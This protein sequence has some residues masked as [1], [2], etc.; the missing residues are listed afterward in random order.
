MSNTMPANQP[1]ANRPTAEKSQIRLP[2]WRFWAAIALQSALIVAVPFKSALTYTT[3]KTVT[4]QTAPVDPYDIFRGYSQTLSYEI[5]DISLLRELPGGDSV[6]SEIGDGRPRPFYVTL[7]ETSATAADIT[8]SDN[9]A[10]PPWQ[11]VAVSL[12]Q[13]K[14]LKENQ[15][16]LQ[17]HSRY[18]SV[19]YGLETY[20]MPE[21]QRNDI[22]RNIA[23][24]RG[25]NEAFVV[26]V[27]VDGQGTSVLRSL[28]IEGEEYRF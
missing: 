8:A 23:N 16:A 5:S 15:V 27:K 4:I 21:A 1:V 7:E 14:L 6:F 25:S 19:R 26:D 24:V 17:G 13:P 3:G 28:W 11:P 18:N 2:S 22:N 12:E 20:Y 9:A 10:P